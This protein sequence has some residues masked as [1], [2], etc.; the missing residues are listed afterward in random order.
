MMPRLR[1]PVPLDVPLLSRD[2]GPGLRW[3]IF[4]QGCRLP[5]TDRCLNPR[6]LNPNV[7]CDTDVDDIRLMI[8]RLAVGTWGHVEGLTLLGGEP[9]DQ[10]EALQP[11]FRHAQSR[12]LSVMLYSGHTLSWFFGEGRHAAR[13]LLETADLLVDGP[14]LQSLAD[15]ELRWRGSRN[16]RVIRLSRRY[17][18]ADL[19]V[20]MEHR[21]VT[22]R[23]SAAGTTT[24]S[25]L[26][27]RSEAASVERELRRSLAIG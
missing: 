22:L 26:Q 13:Q 12:G 7:G 20:A 24:V 8:D 23:I 27:D 18:E 17:S 6:F 2:S 14:F 1:L 10:A 25:G 16:Q 4:L 3:L 21:G 11:V 15:P 5:C 19:V 9:T